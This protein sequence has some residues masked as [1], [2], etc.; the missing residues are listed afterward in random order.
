MVV[1][2]EKFGVVSYVVVGGGGGGGVWGHSLPENVLYF[3]TPRTA[4][5][6][7]SETDFWIYS[8][9]LYCR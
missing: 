9:T 3:P 5:R 4:S 2:N 1:G 7:L 6:G 8:V